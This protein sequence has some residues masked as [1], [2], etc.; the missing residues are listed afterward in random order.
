MPKLSLKQKL[1][2]SINLGGICAVASALREPQLLKPHL[3]AADVSCIDWHRIRN[4][5][6]TGVVLDK[7]NTITPPHANTLHKQAKSGVHAAL[8]AFDG[9]VVILSNSAGQAQY[10]MED[11]DAMALESAL[12]IK[13]LRHAS[14]KPQSNAHLE[15]ALQQQMH[16]KP[17]QLVVV[18]DRL[19]TDVL[20]GHRLGAYT[21]HVLPLEP[22][23]D[24]VT[25][26]FSRC[27]EHAVARK[28]AAHDP[29]EES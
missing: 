9:N 26:R 1:H 6:Y 21:V 5:G 20:L 3:R 8:E 19:L 24:D 15:F 4:A 22:R 14:R 17:E 13:V 28:A 27:L 12:D 23:K 29:P 10:D 11:A 16:C 25:V 18:G 2:Q 7:D